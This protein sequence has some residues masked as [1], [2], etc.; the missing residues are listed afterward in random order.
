M[1]VQVPEE[2]DLRPACCRTGVRPSATDFQEAQ[3]R[4]HHLDD[5]GAAILSTERWAVRASF[6]PRTERSHLTEACAACD[7]G[8][9][10]LVS[11]LVLP[12]THAHHAL[13][14]CTYLSHNQLV[15]TLSQTFSVVADP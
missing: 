1:H 2:D 7:L 5:C 6:S 10:L 4:G 14:R 11:L 15:Q 9:C 12:R 8:R 13:T 3:G